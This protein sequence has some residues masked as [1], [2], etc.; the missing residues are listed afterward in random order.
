MSDYVKHATSYLAD[1][2]DGYVQAKVGLI[3]KRAGLAGELET[4]SRQV[5]QK[6]ADLRA[7]EAA[8]RVLEPEID[9]D[10]LPARQP[11]SFVAFRGELARY[12]LTA[13]RNDPSGLTTRDLTVSIMRDRHMD[14]SDPSAVKLMQRRVGHSL[15]KMRGKGLV[16][17][18]AADSSGL[19]R[20]WIA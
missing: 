13:L 17:S 20:W 2:D 3:R 4:L 6:T 9:V 19:L 12:L 16:R 10:G 18:D 14:A 11:P 5:S 8:L 1:T 7:I 15:M